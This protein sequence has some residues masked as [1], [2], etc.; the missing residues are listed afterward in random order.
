[1]S[2]LDETGRYPCAYVGRVFGW[3][4]VP[5]PPLGDKGRMQGVAPY[6]AK[7]I[8]PGFVAWPPFGLVPGGV[9]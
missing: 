2:G 5:F 4:Q 9:L 1:M 8:Q 7:L 3:R 6:I